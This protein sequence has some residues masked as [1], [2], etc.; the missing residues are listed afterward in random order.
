VGRYGDL[1]EQE[2]WDFLACGVSTFVNEGPDFEAGCGG[3]A[4]D[5]F[6]HQFHG[7]ERMT[8]P[9]NTDEA[10]QPVLDWVPLRGARRV[11]ANSNGEA[12][13]TCDFI[14]QAIFPKA[15]SIAITAATVA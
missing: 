9:L 2:V 15:G 6:G 14:V 3:G 11:V 1:V 8:S 4:L 12:V 10:E 5:V 13:A 7:S